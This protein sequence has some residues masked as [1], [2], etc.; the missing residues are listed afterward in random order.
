MRR[1]RL[2][3]IAEEEEDEERD[4]KRQSI[5]K[6]EDQS[7]APGL[8]GEEAISVPT[9][10]EPP[11]KLNADLASSPEAS[12]FTDEAD[13]PHFTGVPRPP[14]PAKSFDDSGRRMSSQ[15]ARPD[16][17]NSSAYG[18]GK[19]RVKLAPRP[20]AELSGRPRTSAGASTFRPIST[21]PA[22]LK[23]AKTPKKNRTRD[24]DE[25]DLLESPIKEEAETPFSSASSPSAEPVPSISEPVRPHT[26]SGAPA[27]I[28]RSRS[29][30]S[31]VPPMP[32]PMSKQN[33]MTPEKLRL[34][35]A[36]KL[37]E[38]K[39]A[40]HLEPAANLQSAGPSST[41]TTPSVLEESADARVSAEGRDVD[42]ASTDNENLLTNRVSV[43]KADSAIGIDVGA[44]QVS[45]DTQS[46][47]HPAS[48]IATSDIG[49]S[50]QAS[51]L[52][53]ST[54]ETILAAKEDE[55][56][57]L[58]A[59]ASA[60]TDDDHQ[61]GEE[62]EVGIQGLDGQVDSIAADEYESDQ[63]GDGEGEEVP[64]SEPHD[65]SG[66]VPTETASTD[67]TP[68]LPISKF[69]ATSSASKAA[70]PDAVDVDATPETSLEKEEAPAAD[71][72][73][74]PQ[75]R[76]PVSKFSTQEN[77]SPTS[78][79]GAAVPSISTSMAD[80]NDDCGVQSSEPA[81]QE[82]ADM[83]HV[84]ETAS[85]STKRSKRKTLEIR[86]DLQIPEKDKRHSVSSLSDVD[87]LMDELQTATFQEAKP[88]TV[89]KSSMSPAQP[90]EPSTKKVATGLG[91]ESGS[92]TPRIVRTVSNPIRGPLL[93]P[94]DVSTS[95]ARSVSSGAAYLHKITQ[96]NQAAELR[97]KSSKIGSSISQRIKAL[98]KLSST[99]AAAADPAA[100]DRPAAT[101]FSVRKPSVREP[102]R[103]PS[104]ADRANSL[105]R[106]TTP[107]PPD[108]GE[109][110]PESA[111]KPGSMVSRLS[112]FEGGRL[113]RGRPESIQVTARIIRDSA[114]RF[115]KIPDL[116]A[117]PTDFEP[118][119]L[120]QSPLLVDVQKR[121]YS[122]S[123]SRAVTAPSAPSVPEQDPQPEVKQSLLQR[124]FSKG[125]RSQSQER[126]DEE[127]KEADYDGPRPRRRSSLTVVKDFI[128][129]RRESLLGARSPST[130]NLGLSIS[131]GTGGLASPAVPTP[132]RSPARPPSVHQNGLFSRRLSIGSRRSSIEQSVAPDAL[133]ATNLANAGL[134]PPPRTAEGSGDSEADGKSVNGVSDKKSGSVSG[135]SNPGSAAT[136]PTVGKTSG[137][138]ATRFMRRLSNSLSSSRKNITPS[139]S[140]TVAEEDDDELEA[141][142]LGVPQSRGSTTTGAASY[143]QPTIASYMGDVNV[144]FP[145]NLLWKRRTICLDSQGFLILS[146]VQGGAATVP[147]AVQGKDRHHQAGAIKRYHMSDFK[148]PYM[149]EMEL[150]ELPN[151]VVLDF[152]DGSGLQIACEDRAGQM[153]VFNG[154]FP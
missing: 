104:V 57:P 154:E 132:S 15:S 144:Q 100:K 99:S 97:P 82:E 76:L 64:D 19:V 77:K 89:A 139:I 32:P 87:G 127:L 128:K 11:V 23:L 110:S 83:D 112:M 54:D 137:S 106:V 122:P 66:S 44:D 67:L 101:F 12:K 10:S 25:D 72:P 28:T 123:P 61:V 93:A 95:S 53:E 21:I 113:P 31:A 105:T 80:P 126:H 143:L 27:Q 38:K 40:M 39:K 35:K 109:S 4:R 94:G 17:Y 30:K 102:S 33:T 22:G 138:R 34:L 148:P 63:E 60:P 98:E 24:Q 43:S 37:R 59:S 8:D 68:A 5:V 7:R 90:S 150:Q 52:S 131:P 45:V 152:V 58:D 70:A 146:A 120:K 135:G 75:L 16:L 1:R 136:S 14:S 79:V 151:S 121:S 86:T 125:R 41:P 73:P 47:S 81:A 145:D 133:S 42:E 51:S 46:D 48:P 29:F 2:V 18:Y 3:E 9:P 49:E 142:G 36:M 91:P 6:E 129:D 118:L 56:P 84:S 55:L 115:P 88:I 117:D 130:D 116:K 78:P 71:S 13:P 107:S 85:I 74:S 50:T 119:D 114:Q 26:S 149:P 141:A 92:S 140:P 20:S 124:R 69:S 108:S 147:L 65:A 153:T 62:L 111:K 134:S 96:Q 103:S